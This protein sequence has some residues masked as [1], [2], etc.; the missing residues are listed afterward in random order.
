[1][2]GFPFTYIDGLSLLNE[3]GGL[4][5]FFPRNSFVT[6]TTLTHTDSPRRASTHPAVGND[7]IVCYSSDPEAKNVVWHDTSEPLTPCVVPC[8]ACSGLCQQNGGVGLDP[9][10]NGRTNIHIYTDSPGYG[11]QDLECQVTGG[12]SAFIG[13]YLVDGGR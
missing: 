9:P 11:N 10:L 4:R 3:D 12:L 1:M 2:I 5:V 6:N 7:H 8:Q 13:V